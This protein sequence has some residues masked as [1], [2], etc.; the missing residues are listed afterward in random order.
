MTNSETHVSSTE[1]KRRSRQM[2]PDD[3]DTA[4]LPGNIGE[5]T[6]RA[7]R[8]PTGA[9]P[10]A[11]VPRTVPPPRRPGYVAPRRKRRAASSR[12][13]GGKPRKPRVPWQ[14]R[15]TTALFGLVA[16]VVLLFFLAASTSIVAYV[17]IASQL[18]TPSE[19]TSRAASFV[20]SK[21]LDR[22]GNLL[23]E[24]PDPHGGR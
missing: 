22:A 2:G 17:Y 13:A 18:P 3:I 19:L 14:R 1:K 8:V 4:D 20:S 12:G 7:A 15:I 21:I 6:I 10:T 11:R 16:A 5:P 24:V 9:T 23:Y